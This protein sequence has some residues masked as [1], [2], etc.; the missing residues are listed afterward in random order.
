MLGRFDYHIYIEKIS[1]AVLTIMF[2]RKKLGP[3]YLS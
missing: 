2:N 1:W 3:F